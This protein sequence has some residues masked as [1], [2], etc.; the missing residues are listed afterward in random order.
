MTS[1]KFPGVPEHV[2]APEE[3]DYST[4]LQGDFEPLDRDRV[5]C[6]SMRA[7]DLSAII[8]IARNNTGRDQRA[9][10]ESKLEEALEESAIRVSLV[11]ELDGIVAGYVMAR[12]DYGEFGQAEPAAVIDT[13]GVDP[14]FGH[15]QVG[16]AVIDQLLANLASLRIES[17]R[18]EVGWSQFDLLAFL[19]H[20]GFAPSQRLALVRRLK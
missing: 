20:N 13:I 18:T 4:P 10:L 8:R 19:D 15:R 5:A 14:D 16:S 7:D 3:L 12:M 9:Y 17:V 6:R 1:A 11:A 2:D